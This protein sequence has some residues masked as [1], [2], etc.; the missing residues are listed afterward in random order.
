MLWVFG[1]FLWFLFGWV[2]YWLG[3]VQLLFCLRGWACGLW[4]GW[5][6]LLGVR[7]FFFWGGVFGMH[8]YS[9]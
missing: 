1:V 5:G 6:W 4:G 3:T 8:K 2:W 7:G 9:F